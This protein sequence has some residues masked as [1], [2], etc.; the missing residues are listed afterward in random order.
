MKMAL[1]HVLNDMALKIFTDGERSARLQ[2]KHLCRMGL[3]MRGMD[4]A[5]FARRLQQISSYMPYFP[6][7]RVEGKLVKAEPIGEEQLVDA[8]DSAIPARWE[9]QILRTGKAPEDFSSLN[10]TVAYYLKFQQADNRSGKQNDEATHKG[11]RKRKGNQP[12]RKNKGD[13]KAVTATEWCKHCK[14]PT[15]NTEDCWSKDSNKRPRYEKKTKVA[16]ESTHITFS[17]DQFQQ[18][19]KGPRPTGRDSGNEDTF[20]AKLIGSESDCKCKLTSSAITA[21]Y[22]DCLNCTAHTYRCYAI[23]ESKAM[24][25]LDI[26]IVNVV[27]TK[28]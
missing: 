5:A 10:E 27:K 24:E 18:L 4:V 16:K 12:E 14:K 19:V 8:L 7:R 2:K 23:Q 3:T 15:H 17:K 26:V 9:N 22:T 25:Q 21:M 28:S 20:L 11:D 1:E 13:G 6:M